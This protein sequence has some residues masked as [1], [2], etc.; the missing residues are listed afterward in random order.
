[1]TSRAPAPTKT[2]RRAYGRAGEGSSPTYPGRIIVTSGNGVSPTAAPSNDPPDTL[3]ESVIGLTVGS[4]GELKPTQFFSPSNAPTLDQNDEDLGSGGPVALP[5]EYFGTSAHKHLV[6]QVGKDGRIF[7]VDA[8]NMGRQTK[9]IPGKTDAV[10]QTLGPFDGVWGH[11]AAY[12]GQGG[13]VYVLENAG[14]G[15]LR[16]LSY[17]LNGQGTPALTSVA[18][19][20]ESFGYTSGSPLVTSSGTT[21]GSAVVWVVYASG[22]TR[23]ESGT[24]GLFG[25]SRR[26]NLPLLWSTHI[27]TASKFAVPTAYD[28][29]VYVGTRDGHLIAYGSSAAAPVQAA[30]LD[31]GQVAVGAS[32]TLTLSI[33]ATTPLKIT[34]PLTVSGE[35]G[36]PGIAAVTASRGRAHA[37]AHPKAKVLTAGPANPSGSGTVGLGRTVFRVR[38]QPLGAHIAAGGTIRV[39]V[40]FT[41]AHAG[42]DV[43]ELS[44]PTSAEET[45]RSSAHPATAPRRGC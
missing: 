16:A 1:M 10:L 15:Y 36:A 13:W 24:A 14:G 2:P 44:I 45:G 12:G 17:G 23:Q 27:G 30:A 6:V 31:A 37:A 21:A 28:G 7:L 29:R 38:R 22:L 35:E 3:S 18:T 25:G 33:S 43:G 20:A 26:T 34:G 9:Q 4:G 19:S 39:K 32:K 5:T 8:D 11:P 40:T 42:P 41:P